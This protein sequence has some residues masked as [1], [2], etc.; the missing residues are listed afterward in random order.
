LKVDLIDDADLND[1]AFTPFVARNYKVRKA[2]SQK[3][4]E[5]LV[6]RRL[7]IMKRYKRRSLKAPR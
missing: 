7:H 1:E 4:Y 2:I 5:K 6:R 3:E